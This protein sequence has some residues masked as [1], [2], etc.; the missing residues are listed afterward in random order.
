MPTSV[1]EIFNVAAVTQVEKVTY[2]VCPND[3]CNQLYK[4]IDAE[5]VLTCTNVIF[6]KVCTSEL[7]Y[8]R[9]LAFSKTK[10]TPHKVFHFISPSAW[11]RHFFKSNLFCNLLQGFKPIPISPNRVLKDVHDG[12]VW[13]DFL[14]NPLNTATGRTAAK[15]I[16]QAKEYQHAASAA[17]AKRIQKRMVYYRSNAHLF[18]RASS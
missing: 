16:E 6:G 15:V 5:R 11:L 14:V 7:G 2:V 18:S 1:H 12:N 17:E 8:Y 10:W 4:P 13:Q 9:S 3:V